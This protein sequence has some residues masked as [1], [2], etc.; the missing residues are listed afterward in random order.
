MTQA[1]SVTFVF[2]ATKSNAA[3]PPVGVRWTV[4]RN[5]VATS[6][7]TRRPETVTP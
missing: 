5:V 7:V 6:P 2:W 3:E 1:A 4:T